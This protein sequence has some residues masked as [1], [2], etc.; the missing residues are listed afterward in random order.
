MGEYELQGNPAQVVFAD[1]TGDGTVGMDDLEMLL[2]CWSS[3]EEPC[4][5][6]DLDVDGTVSTI[7]LL[8]LLGNWG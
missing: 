4:C 7:D 6:A 1:V 2:D 3:S 5:V 8:I